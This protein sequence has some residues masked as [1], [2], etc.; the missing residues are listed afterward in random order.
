[1]KNY[2]ITLVAFFLCFGFFACT[3]SDQQSKKP[4]ILLGWLTEKDLFK[5]RPDYQQGKEAYQPVADVV[6]QIDDLAKSIEVM[7]LLGTWCPDCKR[8]VPRFLKI[9]DQLDN[10]KVRYKMFGLQRTSD[11]T[12]GMREKYDI[13]YIPT[14]IIYENG[15]EKGRIVERPMVTLEHDLLEILSAED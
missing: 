14:F 9:I 2:M 6:Q 15:L 12:S 5:N 8:E 13:E 1:M 11:D 3:S 10:T 7:I 4:G